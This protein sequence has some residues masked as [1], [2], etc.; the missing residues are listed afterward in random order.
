[1]LTT[2]LVVSIPGE[3]YTKGSLKCIGARGKVKHQLVEQLGA[4]ATDWRTTVAYWAKRAWLAYEKPDKGQPIGAEITFTLPRPKGHYGTGRN[5]GALKSSAPAHPVSH[6]TGDIDKLLRL[7]LD[8][9]QDT[10]VLPDD[11]AVVELNSRKA[12]PTTQRTVGDVLA[13]PGVVIRLYPIEEE[14]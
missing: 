11:C 5:S 8:A 4:P 1:M 14:P 7:I 10:N 2:E 3:P 12:Y 9:L 6:S 13:Y